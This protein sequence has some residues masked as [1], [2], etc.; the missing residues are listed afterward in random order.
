[1]KTASF[2]LSLFVASEFWGLHCPAFTEGEDS[3]FLGCL[4]R[5]EKGAVRDD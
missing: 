5:G 2:M 1:M 3:R 4:C